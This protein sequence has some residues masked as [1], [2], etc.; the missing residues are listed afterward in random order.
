MEKLKLINGFPFVHY[1]KD[2]YTKDEMVV[3][4]TE[5]YSWINKRRTAR[6][7]SDKHVGK[8]YYRKNNTFC[9]YSAKWRTQTTMDILCGKQCRY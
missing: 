9:G 4:A 3:K 7:F 2:F 5:F 8:R 6:G 1:T